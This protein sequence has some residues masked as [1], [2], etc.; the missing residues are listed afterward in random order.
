[1]VARMRLRILEIVFTGLNVDR[2]L[3]EAIIGDLVEERSELAAVRGERFADRWMFS[4]IVRSVP[5]LSL[6]ALRAAGLRATARIFGAA[7]ASLAAI[8]ILSGVSAAVAFNG[9]SPETFARFSMVVLALDLTYCVGGGYFAARLGR[10]SPLVSA[11]AFGVL[12]LTLVMLTHD[13]KTP[14]WYLIALQL[15]LIP[16]TVAGGWLRA[17]QLVARR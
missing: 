9:L 15:L 3:R 4:Q 2:V 8:W 1:M 17:R 16:A 13:G 11:A 5:T 7:L 10:V 6:G 14:S 12:G